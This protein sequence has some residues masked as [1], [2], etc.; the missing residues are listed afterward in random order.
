MFASYLAFVVPPSVALAPLQTNNSRPV[1]SKKTNLE[2]ER[3]DVSTPMQICDEGKQEHL[4]ITVGQVRTLSG[5]QI[6]I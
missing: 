6:L 4:E 1:S 2:K 3:R 5:A